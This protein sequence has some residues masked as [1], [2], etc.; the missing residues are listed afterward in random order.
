M[1]Y[2]QSFPPGL[3]NGGRD[4]TGADVALGELFLVQAG[5]RVG[6]LVAFMAKSYF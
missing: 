1:E 3:L 5:A 6:E 4:E 2:L